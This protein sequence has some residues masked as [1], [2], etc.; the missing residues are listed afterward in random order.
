M[1]FQIPADAELNYRFKLGELEPC[2]LFSISDSILFTYSYLV[3]EARNFAFMSAFLPEF[4]EQCLV[5][6]EL[7]YSSISITILQHAAK[8]AN[9]INILGSPHFANFGT[10][11][12]SA[13]AHI[14]K[15]ESPS[16]GWVMQ[17][18]AEVCILYT[19]TIYCL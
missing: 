17:R 9:M 13:Q 4:A 10:F 18:S 5:C 1:D 16:S 2:K 11:D 7:L 3:L 19:Y 12:Y 6:K 8:E 14:D 15:D